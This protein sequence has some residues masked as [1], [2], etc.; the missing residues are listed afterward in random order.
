MTLLKHHG[1]FTWE[2]VDVLKYKEDGGTHFKDITRQVLFDGSQELPGEV[3]YFNI[4]AD[5]HST[6]ERHDH[7]HVIMVIRGKGHVLVGS[8]VIALDTF[9][10]VHIPSH[11]WHQF[12]ATPEG[13]LGFLCIVNIDRDRPERP[14]PDEAGKLRR[15]PAVAAFIKT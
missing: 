1:D 9:D 5:G 10:V 3:R 6:L 13:P 2:H 11:T 15:D 8:E 14:G 4:A 12:R 7:L